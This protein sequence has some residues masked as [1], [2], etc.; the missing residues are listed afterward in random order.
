MPDEVLLVVLVVMAIGVG[1]KWAKNRIDEKKWRETSLT[2][3]FFISLIAL[4]LMVLFWIG[5]MFIRYLLLIRLF[6]Q[7]TRP[8]RS[9]EG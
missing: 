9:P 5:A 3:K 8:S 6:Q 7:A 4:L 2:R 1:W